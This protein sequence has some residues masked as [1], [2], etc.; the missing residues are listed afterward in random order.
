VRVPTIW[1]VGF[2]LAALVGVTHAQDTAASAAAPSVQVPVSPRDSA[3]EATTKALASELRCPVCQGLSI[4]DSPSELALD[5][6]DV[7]KEQLRAGRSPEEVRQYFLD[8]YG[9]WI[10]LEPRPQG[11]NLVVYLL[12]VVALLGGLAVVWRAVRRWT[13]VPAT[14]APASA[15]PRD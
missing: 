2:A 6:R 8:K 13:A 11:F 15:H 7:I 5:M 14:D 1:L 3:L 9:E 10:L 4:Q 12:P